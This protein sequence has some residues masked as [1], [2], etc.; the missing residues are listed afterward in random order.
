M[1]GAEAVGAK[2]G[3]FAVSSSIQVRECCQ[4]RSQGACQWDRGDEIPRMALDAT[5]ARLLG[6]LMRDPTALGNMWSGPGREVCPAEAEEG[7]NWEAGRS[8]KDCGP[9]W[10]NAESDGFTSVMSAILNKAVIGDG[11]EGLSVGGRVE[12]EIP[13]VKLRANDSKADRWELAICKAREGGQ[14]F[15]R[16]E[17]E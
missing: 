16:W 5:Q 10:D 9:Q 4:G 1:E 12:K 13:E 2:D 11:D 14:S 8:W 7:T 15:H 6:K 3:G 17:H